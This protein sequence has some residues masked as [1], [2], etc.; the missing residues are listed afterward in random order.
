MADGRKLDVYMDPNEADNRVSWVDVA[1]DEQIVLTGYAQCR[2]TGYGDTEVFMN[3]D[4][5]TQA[6][7]VIEED[8]TLWGRGIL[9][10]DFN[11]YLET[12]E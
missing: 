11:V 12:V 7:G 6:D 8:G 9:D 1:V 3:F 10:Q 4:D 2:D 5:G